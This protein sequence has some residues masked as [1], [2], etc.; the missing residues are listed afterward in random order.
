M[1]DGRPPRTARL[2]TA[3]TLLLLGLVLVE[4]RHLP[5]FLAALLVPYLALMAWHGVG[6]LRRRATMGKPEP[7]EGG[8]PSRSDDRADSEAGLPGT[9]ETTE[10]ASIPVSDP[11]PASDDLTMPQPPRRGRTRRRPSTPEPGPSAAS[12]VQVQPGRFIRVEEATPPEQPDDS[13]QY[14][15]EATQ[16]ETLAPGESSPVAA[17]PEVEAE[18]PQET[19]Q[20]NGGPEDQE[21]GSVE[22]NDEPDHRSDAAQ[23]GP[24]GELSRPGQAPES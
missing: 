17:E 21:A 20:G 10:T 3:W 14:D 22:P 1:T 4:I 19:A 2:L 7:H 16:G 15:L 24:P 5:P 18:V 6:G 13:P 12:W 8:S 23:G 9:A 11:V